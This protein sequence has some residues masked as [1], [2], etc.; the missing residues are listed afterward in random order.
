MTKVYHSKL[1]SKNNELECEIPGNER[2][3]KRRE[4][5]QIALI[6]ILHICLEVFKSEHLAHMDRGCEVCKEAYCVH[7]V[8]EEKNEIICCRNRENERI[9]NSERRLE[10]TH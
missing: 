3:N 9:N 1:L 2:Y 4:I 5:H 8:C 7:K 10:V 6:K